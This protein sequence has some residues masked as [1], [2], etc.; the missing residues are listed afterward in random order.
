MLIAP[1][2]NFLE[3][4]MPSTKVYTVTYWVDKKEYEIDLK[5]YFTL[6]CN[7]RVRFNGIAYYTDVNSDTVEEAFDIGIERIMKYIPEVLPDTPEPKNAPKQ[8]L[9]KKPPTGTRQLTVYK[10]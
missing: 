3:K 4:K 7:V 1:V 10:G 8:A 6:N 2:C 9:L 5:G